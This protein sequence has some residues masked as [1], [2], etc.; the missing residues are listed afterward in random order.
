MGHDTR[1]FSL[2]PENF[3]RMPEWDGK[4][5]RDADLENAIDFLEQL[6]FSRA[7]DIRPVI[8]E[9]RDRIDESHKLLFP[10]SYHAAQAESFETARQKRI[11][12]KESRTSNWLWQALFGGVAAK[13]SALR[14]PEAEESYDE[15]SQ[16]RV[17]L[18]RREYA[19]IRALMMKQLEAEIAKERAFYAEHKMSLWDLFGRSAPSPPPPPP[20]SQTPSTL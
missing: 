2:H 14:A 18:R 3:L 17:E 12:I 19:H 15:K 8:A 10:A 6:A 11:E 20:E 13:A 4:N 5:P 16:K 1:G 9:Q 7:S